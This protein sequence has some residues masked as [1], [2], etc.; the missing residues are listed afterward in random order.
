MA[1]Q[2]NDPSSP[3]HTACT[4]GVCT[5]E[6]LPAGMISSSPVHPSSQELEIKEKLSIMSNHKVKQTDIKEKCF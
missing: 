3:K 2:L 4:C 5:S 1:S 6:L